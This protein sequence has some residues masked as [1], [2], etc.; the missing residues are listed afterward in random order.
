MSELD[1]PDQGPAGDPNPSAEP[2]ASGQS[3][4]ARSGDAKWPSR[5]VVDGRFA[6]AAGG[7]A[8]LLGLFVAPEI[9][10]YV[11]A[12]AM[13][14]AGLATATLLWSENVAVALVAGFL[15]LAFA[16]WVWPTGPSAYEQCRSENRDRA[17]EMANP[18]RALHNMCSQHCEVEF[19]TGADMC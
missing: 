15:I 13:I 16:G 5:P 6:A 17:S 3:F 11:V 14:L 9:V 1:D 7:A 2:P 12:S 19:F 10:R 8:V 4:A 18:D